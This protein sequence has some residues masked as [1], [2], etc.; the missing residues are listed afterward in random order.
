MYCISVI[1]WIAPYPFFIFS[2]RDVISQIYLAVAQGK[3]N[4]QHDFFEAYKG[5]ILKISTYL[6]ATA[7]LQYLLYYFAKHWKYS[8]MHFHHLRWTVLKSP[9]PSCATFSWT[10]FKMIFISLNIFNLEFF[11]LAY[12]SPSTFDFL[13][14]FKPACVLPAATL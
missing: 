14:H 1:P 13:H 7:A 12:S 11:N 6:T 9:L 2:V 10:I 8:S 3:Y 5:F 4:F